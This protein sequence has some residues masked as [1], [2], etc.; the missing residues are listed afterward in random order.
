MTKEIALHDPF[1]VRDVLTDSNFLQ[2]GKVDGVKKRSTMD[3]AMKISTCCYLDLGIRCR[4]NVPVCHI[5]NQ[6]NDSEF[7]SDILG[8]PVTGRGRKMN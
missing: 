8:T 7:S 3:Q 4:R 1:F 5:I 2:F 6:M